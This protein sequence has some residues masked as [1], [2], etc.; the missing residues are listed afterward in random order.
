[1]SAPAHRQRAWDYPA[2][3]FANGSDD[4]RRL[5]S[6]ACDL[7]GIRWRPSNRSQISIAGR[8]DVTRLDAL[9]RAANSVHAI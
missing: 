5:F 9:F 7:C 3:A 8:D 2:Y 1:L 4:I 6:W